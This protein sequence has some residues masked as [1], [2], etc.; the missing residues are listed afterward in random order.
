M[1]MYTTWRQTEGQRK[2]LLEPCGTKE[3]KETHEEVERRHTFC[4][5]LKVICVRERETGRTEA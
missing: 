2:F 1:V 4:D 5:D 3:N